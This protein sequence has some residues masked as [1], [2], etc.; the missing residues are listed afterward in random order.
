M[1]NLIQALNYRALRYVS[2]P[3][4]PFQLLVGPNASGKSTF[5]DVSGFLG[6]LVR[7][8]VDAAVYGD[9]RLGV[10]ARAADPRHLTWLRR[11]HRF[12]LAVELPIPD[13]QRSRLKQNG[14]TV[15]RYEVAVESEPS[16][17]VSAETLWLK[18][19]ITA[20]APAQQTF[21]P[22]PPVAPESIVHPA[23]KHA[24][25]GWKKVERALWR[26]F[27]RSPRPGVL[28]PVNSS[29]AWQ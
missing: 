12:E 8:G 22:A 28:A 15:C 9:V 17:G 19:E 18:P 27:Q 21:F 16:L 3:V 1:I 25:P 23:R 5:L 7:A 26:A 10:E 11:G 14:P 13:D 6:D 4:R 24:P 2:Q 29:H 20:F